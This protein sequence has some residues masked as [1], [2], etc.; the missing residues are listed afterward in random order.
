[1]SSDDFRSAETECKQIIVE[2]GGSILEHIRYP[3]GFL[4]ELPC[5]VRCPLDTGDKTAAGGTIV[6][7]RFEAFK[8]P[9]Q[10]P[11]QAPGQLSESTARLI[12]P[13]KTPNSV[14]L[15]KRLQKKSRPRAA[16]AEDLKIKPNTPATPRNARIESYPRHVGFDDTSLT[17]VEMLLEEAR[18]RRQGKRLVRRHED[19]DWETLSEGED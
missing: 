16:Q 15:R 6:V 18:G 13:E 8:T 11:D 3:G 17:M 5:T 19:T 14:K 7:E 10:A 2:A 1:M 9:S 4:F 12:E